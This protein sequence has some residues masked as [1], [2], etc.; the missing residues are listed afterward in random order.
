MKN[1]FLQHC[2]YVSREVLLVNCR[3]YRSLMVSA[4]STD[5]VVQLRVLGGAL[6]CFLLS[7]HL[8]AKMSTGN[9]LCLDLRWGGIP[10]KEVAV[11]PSE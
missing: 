4:M 2:F 1:K 7:V 8:G 10:S 6:R 5:R 9:L 3:G 11:F